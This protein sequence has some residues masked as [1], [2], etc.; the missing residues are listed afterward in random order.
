ME[1]DFKRFEEFLTK[2]DKKN[3]YYRPLTS[4]PCHRQKNLS[5]LESFKEQSVF[6]RPEKIGYTVRLPSYERSR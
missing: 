2:K 6:R 5:T 3:P 1:I 4:L